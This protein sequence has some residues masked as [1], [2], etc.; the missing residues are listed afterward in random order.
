MPES[1][2]KSRPTVKLHSGDEDL[3]ERRT[4]RDYYIILRE[5]LWVAL[6]LAL[7]VALG[8]AY[9][10]S[11]ELPMY[12]STATMQIEKPERVVTSQEVV[13]TTVSS[14]ADLNTYL[15]IIGSQK[16][17]DKVVESLK[18]DDVKILQRP[19]QQ[20]SIVN[21]NPL[22]GPAGLVGGI[23][24]QSVARSYLISITAY[25]RDSDGAALIANR[26]VDQFITYLID[27]VSGR[28]EDAVTYL[29]SSADRLRDEAKSAEQRLL[30]Y[31]KRENLVSLD[32]ST[33]IVR[34]RL[35]S[36][37]AALQSSRLDRLA[38]EN[39]NN[40]VET[41]RQEGKDLL[42]LNIISTYGTIP[43]L[44]T[45]LAEHL[46]NQAVLSE[47]YLERHPRMI[48]M[49]NSIRVTRQ[50]LTAAINL[51]IADLQA[52]LGKARAREESLAAEYA[53]NE[54][55][56]LRLRDLSVEYK[57]LENAAAVAKS[58]Y[59][60]ILDRLSQVN[61][62]RNLEKLPVRRLDRAQPAG[63][64]YSPNPGS[65][66]KTSVALGVL[67]FFGVAF[68]LNF[69]DDRIK[70]A[71]DVEHFIG[72]SLLG[73]VPSLGSIKDHDRYKLF[74]AGLGAG[75]ADTG[76][77]PAT[78]K[79]KDEHATE[80][81]LSIYSAVKI[82]SRLDF[83]KSI[84]VTSTI[85]GEGKTLISCNLAGVF[86]RHGRRTLL[87]DCDLRRPTIH[88][89]FGIENNSGLLTWFEAGAPFD[90]LLPENPHLGVT[91]VGENLD[92]LRSGGRSRT[93]TE[94]LES[95]AFSQL[96]EKLKKHYDLIVV[97]SP[98]LGA[99]SDALLIA[100]RTDEVLYVCRFNRAMRKH[101]KL[102]IKALRAGKNELLGVVLNGLTARRIEYYS[103]YRY[104]RSY[105]KYYGARAT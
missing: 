52:T 28:N 46:R 69:I 8:Y 2:S 4:L 80:A 43:A 3:V 31:M 74:V 45:Q 96:L 20:D 76:Q 49:E 60:Q 86:A 78:E 39:L 66:I 13:D 57:S 44:R 38:I 21:G 54:K 53:A 95:A 1:A 34:E 14:D 48:E 100:E 24:V 36:V 70:S 102:Y 98:P 42:E 77:P 88:R 71:W 84:L 15:Q 56:H 37:N 103:N 59:A 91:K 17:R 67:V 55:E 93:P 82:H 23:N 50:Q 87:I 16:L 63:N 30:D 32:N 94:F 105:K 92:F 5:R 68:G 40:Q 19:Y 79:G 7:I 9:Y 83:P 11:R 25:N 97:D 62:S 51:A 64:P 47:R 41:F 27:S 22:P 90:D 73:I 101:I 75:G 61:T 6:P 58:N 26:Y 29:N 12:Q 99:V 104:Y 18:P 65:I 10:K 72:T 89:H 81:F 33:N 35:T 85:P